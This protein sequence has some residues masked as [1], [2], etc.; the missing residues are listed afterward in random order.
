[1]SIQRVYGANEWRTMTGA[2]IADGMNTPAAIRTMELKDLFGAII[3]AADTA[4]RGT[5]AGEI[6]PLMKEK[7]TIDMVV[8][9]IT[10]GDLVGL[11]SILMLL[12][13]DFSAPTQAAI[14]AVVADNTIKAG[15]KFHDVEEDGPLVDEYTAEWVT[16]WLTVRGYTWTGT[17]WARA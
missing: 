15:A 1:M 4:D 8:N 10:D 3:G 2:E 11:Q 12:A 9:A 7:A 6:R 17:E 13:G 14:N 16:N 5:V